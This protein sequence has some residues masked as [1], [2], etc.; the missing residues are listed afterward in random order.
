MTRLEALDFLKENTLTNLRLALLG[1]DEADKECI[2]ALIQIIEAEGALVLIRLSPGVFVDAQ[3]E[4]RNIA[5]TERFLL[6]A[7]AFGMLTKHFEFDGQHWVRAS[8]SDMY[9]SEVHGWGWLP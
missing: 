2:M 1:D 9:E 7:K 8:D 3:G 4:V 6:V 5:P